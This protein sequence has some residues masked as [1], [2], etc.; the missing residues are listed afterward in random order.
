MVFQSHHAKCLRE[1]EHAGKTL[2][3]EDQL[4]V[5][6][7]KTREE[8]GAETQK[9]NTDKKC[10]VLA[11]QLVDKYGQDASKFQL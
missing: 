5:K 2:S 9:Q 11:N 8:K 10:E 1:C 6:E 7:S 4:I 3:L